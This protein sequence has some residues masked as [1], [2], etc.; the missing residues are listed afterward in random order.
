VAAEN[1][2]VLPDCRGHCEPY[3]GLDTTAA[4]GDERQP[5]AVSYMTDL[6]YVCRFTI[7]AALAS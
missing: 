3:T 2:C 1:Y 6:V 5:N 7:V 4:T